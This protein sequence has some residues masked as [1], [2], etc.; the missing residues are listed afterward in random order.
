MI[1]S[2]GYVLHFWK[3]LRDRRRVYLFSKGIEV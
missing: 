3:L 1:R 2:I